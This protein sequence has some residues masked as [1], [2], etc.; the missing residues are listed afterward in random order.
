MGKIIY[1]LLAQ[2][3]VEI[4]VL[5]TLGLAVYLVPTGVEATLRRQQSLMGRLRGSI[6]ASREVPA[7]FCDRMAVASKVRLG[8]N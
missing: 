6:R 3:L 1:T 7:R 2:L 8:C 5:G 4:W